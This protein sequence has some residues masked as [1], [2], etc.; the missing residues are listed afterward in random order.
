MRQCIEASDSVNANNGLVSA[1][2]P[3]CHRAKCCGAVRPLQI[4]KCDRAVFQLGERLIGQHCRCCRSRQLALCVG[5]AG[6]AGTGRQ[7]GHLSGCCGRTSHRVGTKLHGARIFRPAAE[8]DHAASCFCQSRRVVERMK[9]ARKT[10]LLVLR[11]GGAVH[12]GDEF[13]RLTQ[14]IRRLRN[15]NDAF[16]RTDRP[17]A[18]FCG[19]CRLD[20]STHGCKRSGNGSSHCLHSCDRNGE[21]RGVQTTRKR[22]PSFREKAFDESRE[23]VD[24]RQKNQ[25]PTTL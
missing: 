11:F 19:D 14:R 6:M 12:F 18:V 9:R 13:S 4:V 24:Q 1:Q 7:V 23:L 2:G 17:A 15:R 3:A 5:R 8:L 16:R 21:R 20:R 25:D 22:R 10:P